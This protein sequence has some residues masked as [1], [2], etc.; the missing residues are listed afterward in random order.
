MFAELLGRLDDAAE[1]YAAEADRR[2]VAGL[3]CEAA[4]INAQ[5]Q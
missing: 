3:A 5:R 1:V 2:R 4:Y